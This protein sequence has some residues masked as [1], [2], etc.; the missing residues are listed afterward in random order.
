MGRSYAL[1]LASR[2][3][4]VV[5]ND[6]GVGPDGR[7]ALGSGP[8]QVV[9]EIRAAGGEAV[10]NT[11]SVAD[12]DG[13]GRVVQC[14]LDT[15]GSI[16]IVVNNAGI[17]P[18]ALF[19]E[20]SDSDIERVV[21]VHL[22]GHI[23]MCRAAWPHMKARGYGRLVNVSSSVAVKGM[24]Y[25][26]AY[27]AAKMGV[28]G[29]TRALAAEGSAHGIGVNAIMPN[30]DTLAWQTMLSDD[31]SSRAR[32]NGVVPEVVAPVAAW[33]AHEDCSFSGKILHTESGGVREVFFSTTAGTAP[34]PELDLERVARDI[35]SITD[36][37]AA[38]A[39]PDPD[40]AAA[41]IFKPKPYINTRRH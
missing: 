41:E 33:L 40:R 24:P 32:R 12:R 6:L 10:V 11:D 1:L 22:L 30:A 35:D 29:L 7:G 27:S 14:A 28:V 23:W 5:V 21:G 37:T 36:R 25:Q 3:A 4:K 13:A 17:A 38:V 18:F 31:F 26:S 9:D 20:I 39:V 16:D 15:W 34:D 8:E 19:D 2:G